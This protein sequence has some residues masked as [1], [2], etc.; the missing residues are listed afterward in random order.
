M[1]RCLRTMWNGRCTAGAASVAEIDR[2]S[3]Y[4]N[5]NSQRSGFPSTL[6]SLI[7]AIDAVFGVGDA[8]VE[9][10]AQR[11]SRTIDI[12]NSDVRAFFTKSRAQS[13]DSDASRLVNGARSMNGDDFR[14]AN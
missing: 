7:G 14:L 13:L 3:A 12:C 9:S 8:V 10:M 2:P 1:R 5:I 4:S 11:I 6:N